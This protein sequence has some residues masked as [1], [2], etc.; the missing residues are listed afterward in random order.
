MPRLELEE[1]PA[2]EFEGYYDDE[3]KSYYIRSHSSDGYVRVDRTHMKLELRSAG[4]NHQAEQGAI[5]EVDRQFLEVVRNHHV[6]YAGP[7]AGYTAGPQR[8]K[9]GVVLVTSSPQWVEPSEGD[10]SELEGFIAGMLGDQ[11]IYLY[12]WLKIAYEALRS[13]QF[14]P[15]QILALAG[16]KSSGKSL[17]QALLTEF[18]GRAAMP[19]RYLSGQTTFNS[20]MFKGEHLVIGD[21]V[22]GTDHRTRKHFGAELKKIAAEPVHSCHKKGKDAFPLRPFWRC[23]ISLNTDGENM[24]V[25]PPIDESME[26]K[27]MLFQCKKSDYSVFM[28]STSVWQGFKERLTEQLSH[29]AHWLMDIE[30]PESIADE[31]WGVKAYQ[32]P[33]LMERL[34]EHSPEERM[35]DLIIECLLTAKNP[36]FTG[37]AALI[38]ESLCQ[39]HRSAAKLFSFPTACGVFLARLA[40]KKDGR[41]ERAAARSTWRL[42][43]SQ[44]PTTPAT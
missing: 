7:L 29:M 43:W 36:E 40:D 6:L 41:C 14:R 16:E 15:G 33:E 28:K 27:L 44:A 24:M 1:P 37:T 17:L 19:Y 22:V 35:W 13:R 8:Q 18:F 42:K 11:D 31:R 39:G 21:E 9:S 38:E 12:S 32:H 23:S 34:S 25:L 30:I 10:W 2:P 4:F 26:D 5:S 20:D 3:D